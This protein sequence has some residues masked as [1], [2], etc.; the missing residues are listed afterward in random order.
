MRFG[1]LSHALTHYSSRGEVL[2][3]Q[4]NSGGQEDTI[5][6]EGS[7]KY[8]DSDVEILGVQKRMNACFQIGGALLDL[9][10]LIVAGNLFLNTEVADA[11][12]TRHRTP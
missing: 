4:I 11:L 12:K 1:I 7:D 10:F 9:V 2:R 5:D 3:L 8:A 6:D